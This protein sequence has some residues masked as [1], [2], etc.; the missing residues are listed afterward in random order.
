MERKCKNCQCFEPKEKGG[1][2]CKARA[3]EPQV[4]TSTVKV[5]VTVFPPVD[6]DSGCYH[7][8]VEAKIESD[9]DTIE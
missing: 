1:G 9:G 6:L 4:V 3:P 5:Y 8:F 2:T 7:D